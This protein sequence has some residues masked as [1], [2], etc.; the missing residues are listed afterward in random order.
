LDRAVELPFLKF[1]LQNLDQARQTRVR[2]KKFEQS[3]L[4]FD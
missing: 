1:N 2:R 3:L 4:V